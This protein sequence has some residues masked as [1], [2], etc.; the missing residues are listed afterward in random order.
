VLCPFLLVSLT[1]LVVH[2]ISFALALNYSLE[3]SAA[4]NGM[5]QS[6]AH[7]IGHKIMCNYVHLSDINKEGKKAS[8]SKVKMFNKLYEYSYRA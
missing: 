4:R 1:F 3:F 6:R 2:L 5:S 7:I 8:I